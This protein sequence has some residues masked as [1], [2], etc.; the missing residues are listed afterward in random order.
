MDVATR[1]I[2]HT[3]A[4]DRDRLFRAAWACG[5][6]SDNDQHPHGQSTTHVLVEPENASVEVCALSEER[7]DLHAH[8]A[9]ESLA[10]QAMSHDAH[11]PGK[12]GC[13]ET[14]R[15]TV[16]VRGLL[17]HVANGADH[18][19]NVHEREGCLIET[20]EQRA[21][22]SAERDRVAP[23]VQAKLSASCP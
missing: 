8:V 5:A 13:E 19:E 15:E 21:T 14:G 17:N 12:V 16:D 11:A 23:H 22:P 6:Q 1:A 7:R 9:Y 2:G 10:S 18:A 20:E 4:L 3:S